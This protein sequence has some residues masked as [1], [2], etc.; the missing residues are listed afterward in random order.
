MR[1]SRL[2]RGRKELKGSVTDEQ[3]VGTLLAQI[4]VARIQLNQIKIIISQNNT[5]LRPEIGTSGFL[6]KCS[7]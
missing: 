4:P 7:R 6:Q 3:L 2:R 5:H 1:I